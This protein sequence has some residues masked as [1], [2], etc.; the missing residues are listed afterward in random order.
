MVEVKIVSP[1][2]ATIK[3]DPD[4]LKRIRACTFYKNTSAEFQYK[5]HLKNKYFK[6]N[7]PEKWELH[8]Q[9]LKLKVDRS[10][11]FEEDGELCIRPGYLEYLK[12]DFSLNIENLISYPKPKPLP[13]YKKLKYEPRDYQKISTEELI[14][15]KHANVELCTGAGKT[16]ILLMIAQ[17]LGL[18]TLVVTPSESIFLE[19]LETF[20]EHF[21]PSTI[22]CLGGGMKKLGKKIIISI[23]D[24]V[25]NLKEGTKEYEE[26]S[27]FDVLLG[28]ESHTIPAE[29][30]EAMCFGVLKNIPY[31]FFLSGTQTRGDG[32][33]KLLHSII[34]KTVHTLSTAQA[35]RSGFICDHEYRVLKVLTTATG[36]NS[37]DALEMKRQHFLY[38][39]NISDF[40]AKLS[41]AVY[42][43]KKEQTLVLVDEVDQIVNLVR[44][45]K[46]P[47][48]VATSTNDTISILAAIFNKDKARLKK[49]YKKNPEEFLKKVNEIMTP[50]QKALLELIKNSSPKQAVKDF[51]EGKARVLVGT[52]CISTG[53]N[54]FPTHHTVN[55]Q[56]GSSEIKTKQG[57]IG[58]SVRNLKGSIYE[59]LHA[60]K[61]KSIIWDFDVVGVDVMKRHLDLRVGFYKDSETPIIFI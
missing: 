48:S 21:G 2:K 57:A 49:A 43:N 35:V 38:N 50:E 25:A 23:S 5:R 8:K 20:K 60:P 15:E 40:I 32:T 51:N 13:W 45:L 42:E 37:P 46:I 33:E 18:K 19:I 4:S 24:S 16:L 36:F 53:T 9:T 61:H 1:S 55:W 58:R 17:K 59:D 6:M 39:D 27:G 10:L 3:A 22:G 30:L 54:I 47:Y 12:K 29:T 56:G 34:G 14:K 31:R 11:L 41:Q 28:D 7:Y 26:I 52:S 44:K